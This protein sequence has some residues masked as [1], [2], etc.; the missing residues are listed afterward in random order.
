VNNVR[1][2]LIVGGGIAGM[3]LAVALHDSGITTEIVELNRDWTAL[4]MSIAL[5]APTLRALHTLGLLE[6]CIEAG[7]R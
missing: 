5:T 4:G 3:S 1:K 7:W 6:P 2:L